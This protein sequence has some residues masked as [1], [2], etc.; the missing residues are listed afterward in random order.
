MQFDRLPSHTSHETID[1]VCEA[2]GMATLPTFG[3]SQ[4][5]FGIP[6]TGKSHCVH[7]YI[8]LTLVGTAGKGQKFV[9]YVVLET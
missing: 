1:L 8:L 5:L 4:V 9:K 3:T 2:V 7:G 6:M